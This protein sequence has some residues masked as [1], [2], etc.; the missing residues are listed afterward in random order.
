MGNVKKYYEK[1]KIGDL[2]RPDLS[3]SFNWYAIIV[4]GWNL[5]KRGTTDPVG[6]LSTKIRQL[7]KI[8]YIPIV[9]SKS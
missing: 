8:G 9:V 6:I 4:G 7:K 3:T 1:Y 5:F 2:M